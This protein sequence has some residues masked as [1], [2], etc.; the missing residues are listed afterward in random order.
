MYLSPY[1]FCMHW[2][3]CPLQAPPPHWDIDKAMAANVPVY[4]L[5]RWLC[6]P[7]ALKCLR[8]DPNFV[9]TPGVHYEVDEDFIRKKME[10][11]RS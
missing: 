2:E 5:K 11:T 9:P 7:E 4:R 6:T 1:T 10:C 8:A 3:I